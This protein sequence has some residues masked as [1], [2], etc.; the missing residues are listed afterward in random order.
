MKTNRIIIIIT[1]LLAIWSTDL[2]AQNKYQTS[3]RSNDGKE[4]L[5]TAKYVLV[6][7]NSNN[8]EIFGYSVSPENSN[9]LWLY[10][11]SGGYEAGT[12]TLKPDGTLLYGYSAPVVY[13][14]DPTLYN[15]LTAEVEK[16]KKAA[17]AEYESA[18]NNYRTFI[19]NN[20]WLQGCWMNPEKNALYIISRQSVIY[21]YSSSGNYGNTVEIIQS[22]GL[23]IEKGIAY[24]YPVKRFD[25]SSSIS[26]NGLHINLRT[27]AVESNFFNGQ[28]TRFMK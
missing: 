6:K 7:N 24:V 18:V 8:S 21:Y 9:E 28:L 25:D 19:D 11:L 10:E 13:R 14:K 27:K 12:I 5:I 3:Y 2:F 17:D 26:E 4:M 23:S 16:I 22:P 1:T 15:K 20:P